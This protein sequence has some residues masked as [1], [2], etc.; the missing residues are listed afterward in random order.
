MSSYYARPRGRRGPL[1]PGQQAGVAPPRDNENR[2]LW[3]SVRI[4]KPALMRFASPPPRHTYRYARVS[5]GYI[6]RSG[7]GLLRDTISSK[8]LFARLIAT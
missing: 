7:V 3:A 8:R 1:A 5:S 4:L 6:V 2:L